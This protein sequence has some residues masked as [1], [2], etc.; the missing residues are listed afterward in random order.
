MFSLLLPSLGGKVLDCVAWTLLLSKAW[1][2]EDWTL[3]P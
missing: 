2:L 3:G 1:N